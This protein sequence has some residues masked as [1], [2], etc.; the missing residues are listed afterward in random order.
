MSKRMRELF[1]SS[2]VKPD[3]QKQNLEKR[4]QAQVGPLHTHKTPVS[5]QQWKF[6]QAL[7]DGEGRDTLRQAAVAAGYPEERAHKIAYELT[8]PKTSPHVVAAIQQYRQDVAER[9]GTNLERHLRDLQRIRDAALESGNFGAAV[10]AEYRR[11]QALG[12]IYV[13][14]KEIRHGTIDSMSADEVRKKL[15]EIKAL[16]GGP[17]PQGVLEVLPDDAPEAPESSQELDSSE[18]LLSAPAEEELLLEEIKRA[19]RE[20]AVQRA[21]RQAD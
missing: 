7:V 9:Y 11:G 1:N 10:A 13:D 17:P 20:L 5:P 4:L 18:A 2:P 3:T 15:E 21:A 19:E 8:D 16:Y 14:R 6:V 12:T